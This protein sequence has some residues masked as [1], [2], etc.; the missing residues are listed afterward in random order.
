MNE[1]KA[2]KIVIE[3]DDGSVKEA[4]GEAAAKI[5][6]YWNGLESLGFVHGIQY[7]GP[8]LQETKKADITK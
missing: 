8:C 4:T 5:M 2:T 1:P 3:Y 7:F 6:A